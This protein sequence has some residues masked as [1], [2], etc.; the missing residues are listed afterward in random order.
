MIGNGVHC[1]RMAPVALGSKRCQKR[2]WQWWY[3]AAAFADRWCP[4]S[5]QT[6][7]PAQGSLQRRVAGCRQD[8]GREGQLR[9]A[10]ESQTRQWRHSQGFPT[11]VHISWL[12]NLTRRGSRLVMISVLASYELIN[13]ESN[14]PMT[15]LA[16]L[17]TD[18]QAC[19]YYIPDSNLTD[20]DSNC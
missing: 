18:L 12:G 10:I 14:N 5:T 17:C 8:W 2:V 4:V 13:C 16:H 20:T 1:H 11:N 6:P 7:I 15:I 19:C 9:K 3:R